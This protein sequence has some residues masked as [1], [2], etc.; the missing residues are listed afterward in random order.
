MADELAEP[1][2]PEPIGEHLLAA[3]CALVDQSGHGL[4]P[5]DVDE[6]GLAVAAFDLPPGR[7]RIEEVEILRLLAAPSPA[8]VPDQ[9]VGVL[10]HSVGHQVLERRLHPA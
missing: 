1:I 8:Q 5:F 6:A 9:S 2:F 7:A 4:P 3:A 10:E